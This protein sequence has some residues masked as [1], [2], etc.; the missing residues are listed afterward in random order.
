M[1]RRRP[2]TKYDKSKNQCQHLMCNRDKVTPSKD[3]SLTL[4]GLC[5]IHTKAAKKILER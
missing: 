4:L 1:K 3:D 2:R 5:E